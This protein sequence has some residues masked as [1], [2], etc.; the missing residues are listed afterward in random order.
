MTIDCNRIYKNEEAITIANVLTTKE[1]LDYIKFKVQ[2][3]KEDTFIILSSTGIGHGVKAS[4][5]VK[6]IVK[7]IT[8]YE[9]W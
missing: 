2:H 8:D 4:C 5:P 1:K 7:D 9:S 3:Y 6:K